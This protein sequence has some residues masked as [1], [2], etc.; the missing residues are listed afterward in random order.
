[1]VAAVVVVLERVVV[2]GGAG[3][4]RQ[5]DDC[6]CCVSV[7]RPP[8]QQTHRRFDRSRWRLASLDGHD[9]EA[10]QDWP[11]R[12]Q[13]RDAGRAARSHGEEGR[14]CGSATGGW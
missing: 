9:A 4:A 7:P 13:R 3:A 1:M 10:Q 14:E 2:D 11:Q 6:C 8:T 5:P 12:Q